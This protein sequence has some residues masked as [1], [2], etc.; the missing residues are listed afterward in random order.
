MTQ[1]DD[2]Y[3]TLLVNLDVGIYFVDEKRHIT[4]WNKG[5]E[6]L[7]GY[8][9]EDVLGSWCGDGLLNHVDAEGNLLCGT[10][11]PLK[12]TI[13]DGESRKAEIFLKHAR[14]F[15][16]PVEVTAN[17]IRNEAGKIVGAV[18]VFTDISPKVTAREQIN[19]LSKAAHT[20][21]LTGTAN[22]RYSDLILER[23]FHDLHHYAIP[24]G[25]IFIDIDNFKQVND[26]FGHL[27]G[28]DAIKIVADTLINAVR[29]SDLVGR[30][31]GDE[32]ILVLNSI[33]EEI[34]DRIAQKIVMMISTAEL[35]HEQQRIP[36]TIS[37]GLGMAAQEDTLESLISRANTAMYSSKNQG[38]NRSTFEE[39]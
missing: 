1:I 15:R 14:G 36:I 13:A 22:R 29:T 9:S 38:G 39:I 11:C 7:T 34:L 37:A 33:N 17:P 25:V 16:V 5:A 23:S 31:G 18:E 27:V 4:F 19:E 20:D 35:K 10:N 21:K 32:F 30:W 28:D 8:K 2:F 3:K 24:F 12:D 26:Q 6:R